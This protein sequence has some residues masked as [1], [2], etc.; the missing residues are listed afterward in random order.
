MAYSNADSTSTIEEQLRQ[1]HIDGP[2]SRL[3]VK[4]KKA[5]EV[6]LNEEWGTYPMNSTPRGLAVIFNY[7]N[8]PNYNERKGSQIDVENLQE[9]CKQLG[10]K[11]ETYQDLN[12]QDTL[13]TLDLVG[14]NP[15]MQ[16]ADMLM[17]FMMSHGDKDF[18]SCSD[19]LQL[20]T[21]QI[22]RKFTCIEL[23]GKPKFIVFQACRGHEEDVGVARKAQTDAIPVKPTTTQTKD[24]SWQDMIIAFSTVPGYVAYRDP[25]HGSWF[26]E[27]LVKVFMNSAC[28]KDLL[29]LL[30][31]VSDVM[32]KISHEDGYK[33]SFTWE[34]RSFKRALYF[35]PGLP[36]I[37]NHLEKGSYNL[38]KIETGSAVACLQ[39]DEKKI[40][41]GLWNGS[42]H[43]YNKK[44]LKLEHVIKAHTCAVGCLQFNQNILL[45]GSSVDYLKIW[46]LNSTHE[47]LNTL[48]LE[49]KVYSLKCNFK[50]ILVTGTWKGK[51]SVWRMKS[52]KNITLTKILH[53]GGIYHCIDF[54]EAHIVNGCNG[55]I[56][57]WSTKSILKVLLKT[58]PG[59]QHRVHSLQLKNNL[60]VSGSD[61]KTV[62]IWDIETG[63]CLSK[64]EGH[65]HWITS[66]R[67]DTT[68]IVSASWDKTIKIWDLE[69]AL[70]TNNASDAV[71]IKT[72]EK[73]KNLVR[74]FQFDETQIISGSNDETILIWNFQ[75]T[76]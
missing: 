24:P 59:H 50:G 8:I 75:S 44:T 67:F 23:K 6:K 60:V 49:S 51:L 40:V 17:V 30:R 18:I 61:D 62:K 42:I 11:V 48:K 13:D 2:S 53:S 27:S 22:L 56:Q 46:R 71:C 12:K 35:N 45:S 32:D 38:Q 3:Q 28:D 9:L 70:D 57:V 20:K 34:N 1:T 72:L 58:M 43:I 29:L 66:V 15:V 76:Q 37:N 7:D 21:E 73:H 68:R 41:T 36:N 54:D 25:N 10:F 65:N 39:Y 31:D 26:I 16:T 52:P 33:Q 47:L 5:R 55:D 64:L 69:A 14:K 63:Q 4:V 19:G 74:C